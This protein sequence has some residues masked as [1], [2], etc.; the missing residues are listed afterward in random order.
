VTSSDAPPEPVDAQTRPHKTRASVEKNLLA[1]TVYYLQVK[2]KDIICI[3]RRASFVRDTSVERLEFIVNHKKSGGKQRII[4]LPVCRF[5]GE[6]S[7]QSDQL[8]RMTKAG[9]I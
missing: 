4:P 5:H 3:H 9:C 7:S 8:N 2:F 1:T 6:K